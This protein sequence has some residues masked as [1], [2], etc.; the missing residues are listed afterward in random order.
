ME[1]TI[2]SGSPEKQRSACVVVGVFDN[3]KL[4]LSAELIDELSEELED[5]PLDERKRDPVCP[6][7]H[8]EGQVAA[9]LVGQRL[10]GQA[11]AAPI[12]ALVVGE[13]AAGEHAAFDAR[14]F[15]P[16]DPSVEISVA[17]FAQ[18]FSAAYS[19]YPAI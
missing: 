5:A 2:K 7:L 13:L 11:P 6:L 19:A 3:R 18:P 8:R 4:S 10:R 17:D 14:A 9:V 1:F 12:D 15:D 16:D